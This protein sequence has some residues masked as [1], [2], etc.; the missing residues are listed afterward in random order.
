MSVAIR[1]LFEMELLKKLVCAF[2]ILKCC[3]LCNA[4]FEIKQK[5]L[6][7]NSILELF[8]RV[9]VFKV[10]TIDTISNTNSRE[11]AE[12]FDCI[13]E[14]VV[15]RNFSFTTFHKF[16]DNKLKQDDRK[17]H[18]VVIIVKSANDLDTV[19]LN[20]SPDHYNFNGYFLIVVTGKSETNFN[21][22]FA[23]LWLKFIYNVNILIEH[24][25][26][27]VNMFTFY[28]FNQGGICHD[29][30]SVRIN[31]YIGNSW[32]NSL[33]FPPKLSNFYKCQVRATLYQYI[34]TALK[35]V[36][37]DGSV[38]YNGSDV[39]I[40]MGLS[41]FLNIDIK[42]NILTE[43]GGW[44]QIFEN[45]SSTGAFKSIIVGSD[46]ICANFYY[47][48]DLR[49]KYM[50]FTTAYFSIDM[51]LIVPRGEPLNAL[52]KLLQPFEKPVWMTFGGF[53]VLTIAAVIVIKRQ[54]KSTQVL[55]LDRNI[56]SPVLEMIVIL[57]GSSQHILP[58]NSFSRLLLMSFAMYC[59]VYR[60]IYMGSLFKFLQVSLSHDYVADI[61]V[62]DILSRMLIKRTMTL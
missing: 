22:M 4:F 54:S 57:L 17:K 50:Q 42:F 56:N 59:F 49:S 40:L 36:H 52:Q 3:T 32:T 28:P 8:Q 18:H 34:P 16:E 15:E 25:S 31:Q 5:T 35:I 27:S 33:F 44:G 21:S 2:F 37:D 26:E 24:E 13:K 20:M 30:K 14:L 23:S 39:E 10:K 58:R 55:F 53:I 29:T 46:D 43:D 62:N 6:L 9:N 19:L 1:T 38:S 12:A 7:C 11:T 45:G 60:S 48:T 51:M 61:D 41:K 47:L